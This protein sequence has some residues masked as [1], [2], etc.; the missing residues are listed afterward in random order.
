MAFCLGRGRQLSYASKL[1]IYYQLGMDFA[2]R[3]RVCA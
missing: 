3:V 1:G 2:T